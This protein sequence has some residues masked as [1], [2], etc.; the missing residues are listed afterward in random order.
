MANLD[1][2]ISGQSS[3]QSAPLSIA[4][5]KIE[6]LRVVVGPACT[7]LSAPCA[8]LQRSTVTSYECVYHVACNGGVSMHSAKK[9]CHYSITHGS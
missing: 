9:G 8:L 3:S 5:E 7:L 6:G 4:A 2:L 1:T